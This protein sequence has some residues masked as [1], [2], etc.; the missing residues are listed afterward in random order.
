MTYTY[1]FL[2]LC[3]D[4]AGHCVGAFSI[5]CLVY[6][7]NTSSVCSKTMDKNND[8][9]INDD[10]FMSKSFGKCRLCW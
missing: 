5:V 9:F 2:I 10:I 3:A 8:T 6:D 1:L 7:F 4:R